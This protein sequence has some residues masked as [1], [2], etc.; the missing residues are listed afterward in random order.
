MPGHT[1]F[2]VG[3]YEEALDVGQRSVTMDYAAIDCCH[4]GYYSAPRY[5][6][7]H[8]VAF[9]L[10]AM[11]Q[12][13]HASDAVAVA[14][15]AGIPLLLAR[16]A[17]AAGEWQTVLDV[18]YVKGTDPTIA[19]AR[20]LAFAKLGDV[21]KARTALAEMPAA[22][23]VFPSRI[24]TEDAMRLTV[25]AQIALDQHDDAQALQLLTT[26]SQ[27]ATRGD[28]LAG[29]L[30]MPTLFYYSPHMALAE[31]AMKMGND[32]VARAALE[33]ELVASPH[34]NAATQ[35]LAHLGSG[36]K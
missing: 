29:G 16:A 7:G 15:R 4:P 13:G 6:H 32:K 10:Y 20:A 31:L 17:L 27:Y 28:W 3:M 9:L 23:A 26:A 14:R 24:A 8:N 25:Q 12:T 1:F 11:V 34:S 33:A 5:Y 2:D 22:A 30:E 19:F 36:S 21:A 35:A 18:P